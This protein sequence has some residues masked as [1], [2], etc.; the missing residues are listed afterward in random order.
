MSAV[1]NEVVTKALKHLQK[2]ISL[3]SMSKANARVAIAKD[4]LAALD[5]RKITATSGSY[6]SILFDKPFM[7]GT[8][9]VRETLP[10]MTSCYVCALGAAAIA[11][12]GRDNNLDT[13]VN[14]GSFR[15]RID[16]D[17]YRE[18]LREYFSPVQLAMIESAFE[19][20]NYA[21][22]EQVSLSNKNVQAAI[23]FADLESSDEQTMRR[24]FQNII[25]NKGT[26]VP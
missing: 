25:K 12:V 8:V 14:L 17:E 2:P 26:F 5:A 11:L 19:T 10:S 16:D 21:Y 20:Q 9:N 7:T 6:G 3:R 23:S 24:I 1:V 13:E 18:M 22:K 15:M 4:V